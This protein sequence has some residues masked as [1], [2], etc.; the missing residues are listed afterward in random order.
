MIIA[1]LQCR[2]TTIILTAMLTLAAFAPTVTPAVADPP[3]TETIVFWS[4][5][6]TTG[7][8]EDGVRNNLYFSKSDGTSQRRITNSP[9]LP[10]QWPVRG[11]RWWPAKSPHPSRLIRWSLAAPS[12]GSG[13][14][15]R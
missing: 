2:R 3:Q 10:C 15:M 14:L 1:L 4:S 13:S 6:D 11:P 7:E 9:G 8:G 12:G 5:R